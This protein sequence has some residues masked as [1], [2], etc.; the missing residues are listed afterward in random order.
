MIKVL[1]V[2]DSSTALEFLMHI[3]SQAPDIQVVGVARDGQEA[4]EAV[5]RTRPDV[6][7]MDLNM[8]RMNGFDATRRIMETYPTPIVIVSGSWDPS[9]VQTSFRAIEAGAQAILSRPRGIGHAEC[10]ATARQLVQTVKLM[11]EVKVIR[12]WAHARSHATPPVMPLAQMPRPPVDLQVVALGASTGGPVALRTILSRLPQDFPVP[13]LL[14]QHMA[15]GCIDG[16]VTWL[17]QATSLYMHVASHSE[18][19]LPGHVYVAPDDYHMGVTSALTIALSQEP[20]EDGADRLSPP[21]FG[22][23]RGSLANVRL[24]SCSQV[25]AKTVLRSCT[26]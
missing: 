25:W 21:C 2:E 4:L 15:A 23:S 6:I 13:V 8:P 19:L 12:R 3:L 18:A 1:V 24:A 17:A 11:S 7:T 16:F 5:R 20:P 9:E 10:D 26:R 14:V 22:V